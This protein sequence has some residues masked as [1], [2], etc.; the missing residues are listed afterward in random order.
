MKLLLYISW[1]KL[2]ASNKKAFEKCNQPCTDSFRYLLYISQIYTWLVLF[3]STWSGV[4][5]QFKRYCWTLMFFLQWILLFLK[6]AFLWK[7]FEDNRTMFAKQND[8][9]LRGRRGIRWIQFF[10]KM[11]QYWEIFVSVLTFVILDQ[12]MIHFIAF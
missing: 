2:K 6:K 11:S 3:S 1:F 5:I 10:V 12:Y 9:L 7:C 8:I 4:I